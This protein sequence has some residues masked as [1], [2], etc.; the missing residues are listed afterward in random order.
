MKETQKEDGTEKQIEE[1]IDDT[2]QGVTEHNQTEHPGPGSDTEHGAVETAE[3][4]EEAVEP[5][6][7]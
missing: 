7:K 3:A 1:E 4:V 6:K 5:E 2:R